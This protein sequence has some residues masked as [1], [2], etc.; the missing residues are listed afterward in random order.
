MAKF[1]FGLF[2]GSY[3]QPEQTV[4]GDYMVQNGEYVMVYSKGTGL[5]TTDEQVGAFNL[6]PGSLV[7]KLA[8]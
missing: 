8:A 5:H 2:T 7:K 4:E 3:E 1:K 6:R